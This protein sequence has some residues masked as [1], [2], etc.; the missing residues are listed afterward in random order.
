MP[1]KT[2]SLGGCPPRKC[3]SLI[4]EKSLGMS[5][6]YNLLL[7]FA[8]FCNFTAFHCVFA[9]TFIILGFMFAYIKPYKSTYVNV[10]MSFHTTVIAIN[11]FIVTLWFEGKVMSDNGL[12]SSFTF[13]PLLPHIVAAI[14]VMYKFMILIPCNN[15]L[16]KYKC[17]NFYRYYLM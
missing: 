1:P 9:L 16:H 15:K 4:L 11:V 2:K 17:D 13:F 3:I 14:T 10:S 8:P 7:L 5:F 12:A 6:L